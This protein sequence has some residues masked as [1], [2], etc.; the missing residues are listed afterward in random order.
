MSA[1]TRP[2]LERAVR[3]LA[4]ELRDRCEL[5]RMAGFPRCIHG[6]ARRNAHERPAYGDSLHPRNIV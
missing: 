2:N 6:P 5:C 1:M 4:A 3:D